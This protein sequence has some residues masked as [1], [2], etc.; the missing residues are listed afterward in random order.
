MKSRW[1]TYLQYASLIIIGGGFIY[2]I[3]ETIQAKNTGFEAKTLWDW[4]ELLIIPLVLAIGAFF[5]QQSERAI[6]RQT[7]N[8]RAELE[9]EI[10][11]DRQQEIA[12]QAYITQISELLLKEN[13]RTTK[14]KAVRDVARTRTLTVLRRLDS[15]RKGLVIKFLQETELIKEGDSIISLVG[16]D[17]FQ[18]DLS[19]ANLVNANLQ[20]V[21]LTAAKLIF[22]NCSKCNLKDAKL[23]A[24]DFSSANIQQANLLNANLLG[25]NMHNADLRGANLIDANLSGA[26]LYNANLVSAH[27]TDTYLIGAKLKGTTLPDGTI[28]E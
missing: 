25:A 1:K 28:H 9:R 15:E 27:L 22:A 2:L 21:D 16:A 10:A 23:I 3:T 5:L 14:K 18:A 17:L 8:D 20:G 4:M 19:K 11:K 26:I 6:E 13:L 12:L 7:A 24:T